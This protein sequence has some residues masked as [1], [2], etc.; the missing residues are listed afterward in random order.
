MPN[1][2]P[3][4]LGKDLLVASHSL[5]D[6]VLHSDEFRVVLVRLVEKTLNERLR[7]DDLA[8]VMEWPPYLSIDQVRGRDVDDMAVRGSRFRGSFRCSWREQE[9]TLELVKS[10]PR[11]QG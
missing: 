5:G 9:V 11:L 3:N 2:F 8:I 7:R 4:L 1:L 6:N 10:Q